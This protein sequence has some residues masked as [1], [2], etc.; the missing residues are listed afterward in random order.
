MRGRRLPALLIAALAAWLALGATGTTSGAAELADGFVP[1]AGTDPTALTVH[2]AGIRGAQPL[3]GGGWSVP[4]RAAQPD[5]FTPELEAQASKRPTP[6]PK[7]ARP[8]G[9]DVP[10]SGYIGIRPGSEMIAPSGCT[11][12]FVFQKSGVYAIGTAGHCVE[13]VGEPVTLLTIAPGTPPT[14]DNL[15][16]VEI[17]NVISRTE[18][19]IGAD[20]ALVSIKP[21]LQS[22]VF[23]TEAGVGGPCGTYTADGTAPDVNGWNPL[24][25]GE[26]PIE[27]GE[28]IYHYG[29][30]LGI[31]TTGTPRT[32]VATAWTTDAYY[33]AGAVIF[34][35][36]GS[37]ARIQDFRAAGD[38]TH[39]VINL[40]YVGYNAG[41]RITKMLSLAKGYTLVDSPYC[42]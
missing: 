21:E 22:W 32:G 5:W 34:G 18:N 13:K 40:K 15:V 11:M 29:H 31:G 14:V 28:T 3:D 12:N 26:N 19:G 6:A 30:G 27:A 33:W 2:P 17:G 9:P 41:T 4:L 8:V 39:L 36:S 23:A 1:T 10:L 16:V 7:A 35:D 20:F 37:A 24:V 42:L 38:V 25:K